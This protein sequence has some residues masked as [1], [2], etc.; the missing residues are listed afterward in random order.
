MATLKQMLGIGHKV[1][2]FEIDTQP[3]FVCA[4]MTWIIHFS[5][6]IRYIGSGWQRLW[7]S[8]V[9][10]T[11][12]KFL[13]IKK[14]THQ[15][16]LKPFKCT[17]QVIFIFRKIKEKNFSDKLHELDWCKFRH[18]RNANDLILSNSFD[19]KS[20]FL[21]FCIGKSKKNPGHSESSFFF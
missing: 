12:Q 6:G 11:R 18:S 4:L 8:M 19:L 16:D 7:K 1:L 10:T 5:W 13:N 20:Y 17:R 15:N 14:K 2:E 3:L 9:I 21:Y